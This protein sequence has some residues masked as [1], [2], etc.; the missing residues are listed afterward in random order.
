MMAFKARLWAALEVA[1]QVY[2]CFLRLLIYKGQGAKSADHRNVM[3]FQQAGELGCWGAAVT[4]A[5]IAAYQ[6]RSG[7]HVHD[8]SFQIE[9]QAP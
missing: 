9:I 6:K 4:G 7:G 2:I 8:A 3:T 1:S 5:V